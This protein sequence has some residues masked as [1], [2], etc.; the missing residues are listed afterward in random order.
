MELHKITGVKVADRSELYV[1]FDDGSV[2][3]IDLSPMLA[4]GGVFE[5]LRDSRLFF[6]VEVGPR[7]R[8]LIWKIGQ[9][10]DDVVD[11]CAD[12]LWL[13]AQPDKAPSSLV[14]EPRRNDR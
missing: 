8:S 5:P 9:G 6:S 12:S 3:L 7:G 4:Q 11:L 2:A 1:H 14:A 13:M 10:E